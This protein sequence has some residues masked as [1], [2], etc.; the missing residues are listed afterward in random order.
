MTVVDRR[1]RINETR[2]TAGDLR[3]GDQLNYEG[4][5]GT[6][7][8]IEHGPMVGFTLDGNDF[9]WLI[10]EGTELIVRRTG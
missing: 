10:A 8:S 1:P 5:T 3:A 4:I 9:R 6:I 2:T 7:T